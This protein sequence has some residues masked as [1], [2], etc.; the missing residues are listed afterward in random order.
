METLKAF[1]A[2]EKLETAV[3]F[4]KEGDQIAIFT[5]HDK[6]ILNVKAFLDREKWWYKAERVKK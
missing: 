5:L 2:E 3:T 1:V 4:S 6:K